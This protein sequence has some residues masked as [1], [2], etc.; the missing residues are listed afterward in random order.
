MKQQ[1]E[2][3]KAYSGSEYNDYN[4]VICLENGDPIEPKLCETRFKK[5]Q[6]RNADL[7]L[8]LI[9]FHRLHH[10]ATTLLMYLSGSDAKTVQSITGHA[11]AE[12]VFD[13]YNHSLMSR[14]RS[15][16]DKLEQVMYN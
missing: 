3:D 14:Q 2:K 8:P 12:F 1:L 9:V 11:S 4:L 6:M 13:T 10:S 15:L 7:D 16:I 5:W